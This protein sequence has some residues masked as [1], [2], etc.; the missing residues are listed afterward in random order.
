MTATADPTQPIALPKIGETFAGRYEIQASLGSGGMS[1]V[2]KARDQLAGDTVA[3]KVLDPRLARDSRM[4]E[5]FKKELLGARKLSHKNV[6]RIHDIGEHAGV[7]FISMELVDGESLSEIAA[8][9]GNFNEGDFLPIFRQFCDA[10][11][12]IHSQHLVHR[13][14]K[15]ANV[16]MDRAGCLKLMDFGIARDSSGDQTQVLMGTPSH[17]APELF[18]GQS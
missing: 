9:K 12:Y 7:L 17:M 6:V 10:L 5:Q 15:A 4:I 11:G 8:R 16:M 3:I 1:T 18:K 14:I 2:Y 13:D